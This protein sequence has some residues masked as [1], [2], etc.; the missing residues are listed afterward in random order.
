M[1]K[2][3]LELE[4]ALQIKALKFPK[5]E[6][7]YRF[8]PTRK[9]PFDFAWPLHMVAV[10]V[11]GGAPPHIDKKTGKLVAGRHHRQLEADMFKYNAAVVL[12]W[13]LVRFTG[14][15]IRSGDA[16]LTL[17]LLLPKE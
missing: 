2:S 6:R 12:G 7:E 5:P 14:K 17:E 11:E 10:E 16:M 13:K 3:E 9:W 15:M 1:S 4:L 8:H